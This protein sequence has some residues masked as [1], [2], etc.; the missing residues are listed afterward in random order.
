MMR[1]SVVAPWV[2][3]VMFTCVG[4]TTVAPGP[5]HADWLVMRDGSRVETQG[6]WEVDGR[7]VI[8]TRPNGTLSVLRKDDVDLEASAQATA[9]AN[10]PKPEV[11]EETPE[12]AARK[13]VLVLN[14]KNIGPAAVNRDPEPQAESADGEAAAAPKPPTPGGDR[15]GGVEVT[16]WSSSDSNDVDGLEIQGTLKNNSANIA[17]NVSVSVAVLDQDEQPIFETSAFL[18][19][20]GLAPGK[21]TTFR[22]L[23]PGVFTLFVDPVFEVKASAVTL[24]GP[25]EQTASDGEAGEAA[26]GEGGANG[27]IG[28][29][30]PAGGGVIPT[31]RG[32][33]EGFE[34]LEPQKLE[35]DQR[36]E[37]K[38]H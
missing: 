26:D 16:S 10:A 19:S 7:K 5:A 31:R 4:L 6:A 23:L 2:A 38:Q 27:G 3:A 35:S 32:S 18:R 9:A 13:P 28:G 8:F 29:T 24:R 15:S 17:A 36:K 20:T 25:S 22:A 37:Q 14:N 33:G 21:S 1:R 30:D 12:P 34:P 11:Q